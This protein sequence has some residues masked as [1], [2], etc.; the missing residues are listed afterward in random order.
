MS[1][2]PG[3]DPFDR[4]IDPGIAVAEASKSGRGEG[5][6]SGGVRSASAYLAWIATHA[7]AGAM[8]GRVI[9]RA[10]PFFLMMAS[11]PIMIVQDMLAQLGVPYIP[12][13]SGGDLAS[14]VMLYLGPPL[15]GV[16]LGVPAGLLTCPLA[17]RK[18]LGLRAWVRRSAVAWAAASLLAFWGLSLAFR[19]LAALM[20]E[21][22]AAA[23]LRGIVLSGLAVLLT[24]PLAWWKGRTVRGRA[25]VSVII[26]AGGMALGFG[27]LALPDDLGEK[28]SERVSP[29]FV[30]VCAGLLSGRPLF[31]N[32]TP[33]QAAGEP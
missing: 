14:P 28:I 13:V 16:L 23:L 26:L 3:H 7:V 2:R 10:Y 31:R 12:K 24:R 22:I 25:L 15:L 30:F 21:R 1:E 4:E 18:G 8:L 19:G 11:I 29:S 6:R 32:P 33:R 9:N 20:P 27:T 17:F 5:T